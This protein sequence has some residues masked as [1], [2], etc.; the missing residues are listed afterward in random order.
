LSS[1]AKADDAVRQVTGYDDS[2]YPVSATQ[3]RL[4]ILDEMDA[5]AAHGNLVTGYLVRGSFDEKAF[6]ESLRLTVLRHESLRTTFRLDG[7]QVRAVVRTDAVFRIVRESGLAT[8]R[9]AEFVRAVGAESFDLAAG[10]LIRCGLAD[11]DADGHVVAL[12]VHRLVADEASLHTILADVSAAYAHIIAGRIPA[13]DAAV[14]YSAHVAAQR[15]AMAAE[16]HAA[17]LAAR[18]AELRSG[19]S[20]LVLPTDAARPRVRTAKG[21][22]ETVE[23]DR[24]TVD[25]LRGLAASAHLP[26]SE[27][28]LAGYG[29]F[30]G[31]L[32][33]S[34]QVVVGVEH[35]SRDGDGASGSVGPYT[36]TFPVLLNFDGGPTVAGM[37]DRTHAAFRAAQEYR[38]LPFGGLVQALVLGSPEL[39]YDPVCQV[40]I[41]LD[42]AE[43]GDTHLALA[44]AVVEAV[45]T[46]LSAATADMRLAVRPRGGGLELELTYRSGL[47]LPDT[48]RRWARNL[49]GF[50]SGLPEDRECPVEAVPVVTGAERV[51]I[52]SSRNDT[53]VAVAPGLVHDIIAARAQQWPDRQAVGCR[54]VVL[55]YS[56]LMARADSL[57][58]YLRGQG[59]GAGVVV[60]LCLVRSVEMAVAVLAVL[61]AGG[62]YLPL[63]PGLPAARLSFMVADSAVRLIVTQQ[64]LAAEVAAPLGVP[65]VILDG[66]DAEAIA[67]AGDGPCIG[68]QVTGHDLAYIIYT[69]GSTGQPKGVAVEH[70]SLLNL[71]LA[72]GPQFGIT[73]DSRVLQFAAFSFDVSVSDMFFSWVA[74]AFVQIAA[75]DE[76]LGAALHER[77]RA[78]RITDV[79]LPP[80]AVA[81]LPWAPGTLPDLTTLVVGG[82]A[83]SS[84]LVHGWARDRRVI[85][86]YGPTESTVWTTL[87]ELRQGDAPVIG[88][89]LAN[90]QVYVL[91]RFL[92]PVPVGVIAELFIGGAGVVR[93]YVN[94]PGLTAERFIP[95]PFGPPGGRMYRTGDLVRWR[96]DGNLE[97]IGR[98]DGQVKVRGFR[99]ELG[100]IEESLRAHAGVAQAVVLARRDGGNDA[101]QVRLVAYVQARNARIPPGELRSWLRDRLPGYM[102]PEVFVPISRLP[103]TRAGKIDRAALPAPSTERPDMQQRYIAPRTS[104]EERIAAIWAAVLGVDRVGVA[105]DFFDLGGN[106]LRMMAMRDR[107]KEAFPGVSLA[108]TDLF[109]RPTVGA[110]A[111]TLG[112]RGAVSDRVAS[113]EKPDDY[114]VFDRFRAALPAEAL[115]GVMRAAVRLQ[116]IL[117]KGGGLEGSTVMVAYGGGKDSSYALAFVRGIQLV[118]SQIFGGTFRLR[119]VTIRHA[120]M[121]PAVMQNIDRVYRALEVID[122]QRCELLLVDGGVVVPYEPDLPLPGS[123]VERGRTDILMSGHRAAGDGRPT[124]CNACNLNMVKA[125]AVAVD[126]GSGVDVIVTGDS[127]Q[128]QRSYY[129]WMS[130]LARNLKVRPKSTNRQPFGRFLEMFHGVSR[131]YLTEIY[132][133]DSPEASPGP[134][135]GQLP[136]D[137]TFFSIY[138]DTDYKS[139]AHWDFLTSYLGFVFDDLAFSFTESDCGNPGLM[140]HLRGLKAE[141]RYGRSYEVGLAE[142]VDFAVGLMR[143]K[144]FP[145]HL[146]EFIR[147]RYADADGVRRMREAMDSYAR[148]THRLTE[149]QLVCMVFAPFVGQGAALDAYLTVIHPE[150]LD[151]VADIRALLSGVEIDDDVLRTGLERMSGLSIA[152]LRVL[153]AAE[154]LGSSTAESLLDMILAG[155]PHKQ[156]IST[157]MSADGPVV[158]E[159]ISG[160]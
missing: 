160:R 131:A 47:F 92:Q 23:L 43:S 105:D 36:D 39:S 68:S 144:D 147:R 38:T 75:E 33:G 145:E 35:P 55:S 116:E 74:G 88:K 157:Q 20:L 159:M 101:A 133:A 67:A 2:S 9:V 16:E 107:L 18:C 108:L 146:I 158:Q 115:S 11:T 85:N 71:A 106:S 17:L 93:G 61:R 25:R 154:G 104:I 155:D 151:R 15:A 153:Y 142:Y 77:L 14:P 79:T 7:A 141:R 56:E 138:A 118:L 150:L 121:P 54:D 122:D 58:W 113:A 124:F 66:A 50:L 140:A 73:A 103:T 13:L 41:A 110:L 120:G 31:R 6:L 8:M 70:D 84:D 135:P 80:A 22:V 82:E 123:V 57:A 19:P 111:A 94:Q 40:A 119:V 34:S 48:V 86:A 32:S 89:P 125:F 12:C 27:V 149:E 126:Y 62:A 117:D 100:E 112:R 65:S 42:P 129:V 148:E 128:E 24:E 96:G 152:Q 45:P 60:G 137:V 130:R 63:D 52:V 30:L 97:F 143:K 83:F 51:E 98:R 26:L 44:G 59:V 3:D 91:D 136:G 102:V 69:S 64:R 132:G 156:L 53:D 49:R 37:L 127:P 21:T 5:G 81:T 109:L 28:L 76:R 78:S 72:Q 1:R 95:D 46:D 4:L 139:G 134:E 114:A 29:A 99:I 90:L 87:A 10:P